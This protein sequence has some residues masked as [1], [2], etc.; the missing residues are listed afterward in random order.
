MRG[1]SRR[2][3]G[4]NRQYPDQSAILQASCTDGDAT[5]ALTTQIMSGSAAAKKESATHGMT[6]SPHRSASE[7]PIRGPALVESATG[8][9]IA[10]VAQTGETSPHFGGVMPLV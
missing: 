7:P 2:L 9:C 3:K 10:P 8:L 4:N 5:R 1:P 6:E